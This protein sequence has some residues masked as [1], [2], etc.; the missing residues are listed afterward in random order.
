MNILLGLHMLHMPVYIHFTHSLMM[1]MLLL[2]MMIMMEKRGKFFKIMFRQSKLVWALE[3]D[4]QKRI[5]VM[6][7][8]QLI[9]KMVL[10]YSV[11]QITFLFLENALKKTTEY[12]LQFLFLI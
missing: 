2:M 10:I 4:W 7:H 1:L 8:L 12:F 6:L 9:F 5:C 3:L 11:R